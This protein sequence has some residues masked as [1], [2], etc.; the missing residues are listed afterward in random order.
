MFDCQPFCQCFQPFLSTLEGS[1]TGATS[2]RGRGS[3]E[4][5]S[6]QTGLCAPENGGRSQYDPG[7]SERPSIIDSPGLRDHWYVV[8]D[9]AE[10]GDSPLPVT[11]LGDRFVVWRADGEVRAAADRCPHREAPLSEGFMHDGSLTCAYHGWAF[12]GDGTCRAIPASG[13]DATIPTAACLRMLPVRELYGLVWL[14]P[15]EAAGEPPAIPQDGDID[16]RRINTGIEVWH[17]SVTRMVD[18]FCD[19]AHFPYVHA[20]TIGGDVAREVDPY[21]VEEL[22]DDFTGFRYTVDVDGAA[23]EQVRQEMTTGFALPFTVR[24][25]THHTSGP[26]AGS[27]RILLL[28]SSPI[29]AE[30]TLFTFVLWRSDSSAVSDDEQVA[31]DRAIGAEDRAMLEL[32]PGELS[33]DPASTVSGRADRLSVEWRRRL[34]D[35][36]AMG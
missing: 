36:V 11:L 12:A 6:A 31:F 29:D 4:P 16:Y 21:S 19:I 22:D 24:S 27:D 7:V 13:L 30:R 35:S 17:T 20:A 33:L 3:V 26:D 10:L 5:E 14:S 18:N 15:G 23:A 8:A 1:W 2:V 28:C 32:V 25:T 34:A 9:A